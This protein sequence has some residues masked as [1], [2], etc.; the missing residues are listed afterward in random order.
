MTCVTGPNNYRVLLFRFGTSV[1]SETGGVV[2]KIFKG[3][4]RFAGPIIDDSA[5]TNT[6][7]PRRSVA[8]SSRITRGTACRREAASVVVRQ[9]QS[10]VAGLQAISGG[11]TS[12]RVR[13]GSPHGAPARPSVGECVSLLRE[14]DAGNPPVRF[15]EREQETGS[16]QA[17]LRRRCESIVR[18]HRKTTATAPVLDS[19]CAFSRR[20]TQ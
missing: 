11:I 18:S 6:A 13:S 3:K 4:R 15:D 7:C 1:H 14:P 8:G 5:A 19:T 12:W 16:G 20:T 9:T 2:F 17:G 10:E